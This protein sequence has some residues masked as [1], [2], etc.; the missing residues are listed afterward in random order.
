MNYQRIYDTIIDHGKNRI[1]EGYKEKHHI[2]PRCLGGT[3][4]AKNLVELTAEE[5]YVVHQL[6]VKIHPDNIKLVS[7]AMFMTANGAGQGRSRN[8]TYGWLKRRYSAYMKENN[9]NKGG[10]ARLKYIEEY[11]VPERSLDFVTKEWRDAISKRMTGDS[12]PM[13]GTKPWKHGRAT[14]YTK[15]IWRNADEIYKIWLQN[16]RPSYC[17]LLSLTENGNYTDSDYNTKVGPFMNLVKYFRNG[18]IPTQDKEWK[19]I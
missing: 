7:A 16:D 2:V 9:P 8:K 12:N 14:D 15:S 17:R 19:K 4:D 3:N 6:L 11:G 5:H 18:W 10:V 1:L 13:R